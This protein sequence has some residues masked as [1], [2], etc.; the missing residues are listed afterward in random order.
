MS[1]PTADPFNDEFHRLLGRL[2]HAHA[3]FDFNM[4]LQLRW[5]GPHNDVPVDHL[6][7]VR[8]PFSHRL[9]ALRPLVLAT[10]SPAGPKAKTEFEALFH[11]A[12]ET[13][14]LRNDYVHGR[15]GVPGRRVDGRPLLL[16]V[17][18]HWN[19]EPSR[20][21]DSIELSIEEFAEQ[22]R[23]V[24]ALAD[25]YHRLTKRYLAFAKPAKWYERQLAE[26]RD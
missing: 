19:T 10:F 5:L 9:R 23:D 26:G 8:V 20:P 16:F 25:D 18:L 12:D 11:R 3:R 2:V 4:G 15:W 1:K 17:P 21:D 7:D 22:V 24:E 6:L 13:K 14:A